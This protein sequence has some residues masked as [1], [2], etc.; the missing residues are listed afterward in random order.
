MSFRRLFAVCAISIFAWSFT[1]LF[2]VQPDELAL[3]RRCG[4]LLPGVFEPGLH[5]GLPW[6]IDRVERV[7]P[8]E[9][10]R[11]LVG[12]MRLA[13]EAA[14]SEMPQLLTG[15]RNLV[16]VLATVQ[17]VITD[18][19]HFVR[20]RHAVDRLVATAGE[21]SLGEVM[22]SRPVDQLLTQGKSEAGPARCASTCR[23][24]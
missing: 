1:A 17:Y 16:N 8:R 23:R 20:Q 21:A 10:R 19:H 13:G 6:G 12:G 3:V 22:A 2:V 24:F 4:R 14:G 7:K 9:V 11:V 15:D 18:P 5:V